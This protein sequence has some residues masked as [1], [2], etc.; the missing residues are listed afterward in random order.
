MKQHVSGSFATTYPRPKAAAG[1]G[2][3]EAWGAG[4]SNDVAQLH[5]RR[6]GHRHWRTRIV[7]FCGCFSHTRCCNPQAAPSPLHAAAA[8]DD[9]VAAEAA[10]AAGCAVDL[11]DGEGATPLHWAADRGSLK[12]C[13]IDICTTVL[14]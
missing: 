7:A 10:L 5:G 12:V 6:C 13:G 4:G 3:A 11:Q 9:V 8:A 14:I 1:G 2:S